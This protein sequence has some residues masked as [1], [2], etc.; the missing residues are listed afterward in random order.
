MEARE[1]CG[2]AL[3]HSLIENPSIEYVNKA[4]LNHFPQCALLW[5]YLCLNSAG[6]RLLTSSQGQPIPDG[7][8]PHIL[9]RAGGGNP[10]FDDDEGGPTCIP[11]YNENMKLK[12]NGEANAV[13]FFLQNCPKLRLLSWR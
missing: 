3:L 12:Y 9:S 4:C 10:D 2:G 5:H 6:R 11:I 7:L 8:W 13:Y 1:E